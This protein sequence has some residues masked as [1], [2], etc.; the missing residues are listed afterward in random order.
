MC[1]DYMDLNTFI[2]LY[3]EFLNESEQKGWIIEVLIEEFGNYLVSLTNIEGIEV[4]FFIELDLENYEQ[5]SETTNQ[6]ML[7]YGVIRK[8]GE[9]D[10]F[11]K[12]VLE[13]FHKY[14]AQHSTKRKSSFFVYKPKKS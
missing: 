7:N 5:L 13:A 2:K 6:S 1:G 8:K 12:E 9:G 10:L 11:A 14:W 4:Q 3:K